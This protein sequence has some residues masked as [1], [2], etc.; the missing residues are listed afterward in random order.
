MPKAAPTLTIGVPVY[1]EEAFLA[2]ALESLMVQTRGDWVMHI[3]DNGSTDAT[4][5]ICRDAAARDPRIRYERHA[6]NQGSAFNW[7]HVLAEVKT[8]YV[9]FAA[10]HDRW[11]PTF[12]EALL[13]LMEQP[14]VILAYPRT[15]PLSVEGTIG[16]AYDDDMTNTD[17]ASPE[18]RFLD[19]VKRL[20][21]C[22]LL[23]GVWRTEALR[24]WT[25]RDSFASDNLLLAEQALLGCFVQ[26]PEP[27]FYRRALRE[28]ESARQRVNRAWAG[29]TGRWDAPPWLMA[30][31][32]FIR[33]HWEIVFDERFALST[34][35]RY[36]L[37]ART[38]V[39]L[40]RR[41][42]VM[43][44]LREDVLSALPEPVT[45]G[46]RRLWRLRPNAMTTPS[47]SN[48]REP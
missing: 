44:W 39:S 24:Q 9:L 40:T 30:N 6:V 8:P 18:A 27:L 32:Q 25:V 29:V 16:P 46:L 5:E 12:L 15:Y 36:T 4:E 11:A 19:I 33:H 13:P 7:S 48:R 1:N 26:H 42:L 47:S 21:V 38:A 14:Q 43:P 10:G 41:H 37:A 17:L 45:S 31:L 3:S 2:E 23:G 22:N 28:G 20:G 35:T 34:S